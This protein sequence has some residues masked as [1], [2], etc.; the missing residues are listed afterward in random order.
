MEL[1]CLSSSPRAGGSRETSGVTA[2]QVTEMQV[3]SFMR[4]SVSF[5]SVPEFFLEGSEGQPSWVWTLLFVHLRRSASVLSIFG[6]VW[7]SVFILTELSLD[8]LICGNVTD[9][10]K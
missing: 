6:F 10:Y 2:A 1:T 8:H 7:K 5:D 9:K 3:W 4:I